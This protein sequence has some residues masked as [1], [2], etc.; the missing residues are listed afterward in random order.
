MNVETGGKRK[1]RK[2][3]S[4]ALYRSQGEKMG[5]KKNGWSGKGEPIRGGTAPSKKPYYKSREKTSGGG[6]SGY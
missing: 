5:Q 6:G 1:V 2:A 4:K 3:R